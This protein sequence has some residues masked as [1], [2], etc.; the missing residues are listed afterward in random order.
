M[1]KFVQCLSAT[2][3]LCLAGTTSAEVISLGEFNDDGNVENFTKANIP[4]LDTASGFLNGT[5]SAGSADPQL[6]KNFA[7]NGG[8]I[9]PPAGETF[10]TLEFRIQETDSTLGTPLPVFDPLGLIFIANGTVLANG[11]NPGDFV[12]TPSTDGFFIVTADITAQGSTPISNIRFDPVGGPNVQNNSFALDYIRVT[13]VPEPATLAL[14]G[15]GGLALVTRR[16]R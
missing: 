8:A 3:A 16:R 15:L 14:L 7:N 1:L 4:L 9:A 12:A 6:F 10:S 5:V 13:T 11:I 2:A